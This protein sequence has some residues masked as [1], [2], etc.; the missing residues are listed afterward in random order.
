[1][2]IFGIEVPEKDG[3]VLLES[4]LA[5]SGLITGGDLGIE[6]S[7]ITFLV[8]LVSGVYLLWR[9]YEKGHYVKPWWNNNTA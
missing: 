8:V 3:T 5:K 6:T 9:S 4:D 2:G 1:M 7:V